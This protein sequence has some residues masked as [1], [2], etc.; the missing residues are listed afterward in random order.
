MLSP[1][2]GAHFLKVVKGVCVKRVLR[3]LKT[4]KAC[5]KTLKRTDSA[6][7]PWNLK[8]MNILQFFLHR[9]T[10][11]RGSMKSWRVVC[12][13]RHRMALAQPMTFK[14]LQCSSEP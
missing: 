2:R 6:S 3:P 11:D 12:A 4:L 1:R 5:V 8:M 14:I 13:N 9:G 7:P 10:E